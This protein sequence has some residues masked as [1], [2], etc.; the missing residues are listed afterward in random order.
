MNS[1]STELPSSTPD[2]S[3]RSSCLADS[4]V[5]F[6]L[7]FRTCHLQIHCLL[8]VLQTVLLPMH[9]VELPVQLC[10]CH[11]RVVEPVLYPNL[12]VHPFKISAVTSAHAAI[13]TRDDVDNLDCLLCS[14]VFFFE[15]WNVSS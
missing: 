9:V 14:A 6:D 10:D 1:P 3:I 13:A 2:R 5:A 12:S 4:V 15:A 7:P 8:G 11:N